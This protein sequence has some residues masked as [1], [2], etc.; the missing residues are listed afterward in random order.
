[1][2]PRR[3]VTFGTRGLVLSLGL[4]WVSSSLHSVVDPFVCAV[5]PPPTADGAAELDQP[6]FDATMPAQGVSSAVLGHRL[7]YKENIVLVAD[8][9]DQLGMKTCMHIFPHAQHSTVFTSS[10]SPTTTI[11]TITVI[12]AN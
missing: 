4:I 8:L 7:P 10:L 5:A 11:T 1:M 6:Q 9:V 12:T 2:P 3:V